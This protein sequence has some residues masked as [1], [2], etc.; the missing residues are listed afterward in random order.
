ME[1]GPVSS[2]ETAM[3]WDLLAVQPPNGERL[4]ARLAVP[5]RCEDVYI[6]VDAALRRYVLI[7]VPYGEPATLSE[8]VSRGIAVQTVEMTVDAGAETAI[9]VEV[10]CLESSGHAA[11]D[12]VTREIVEALAAGA[13]LGRIRL[14]QSVLAKWRRF[15]SGIAQNLLSKEEQLGLFGELWFL[16]RWLLPSVGAQ[17]AVPMW[18]G[19]L[20]AR[21]DFEAPGLA[22]EVK[23]SGRLDG[24]HRIHGL[25]QLLEPEGGVLLLFSLLVREEGGGIESLPRLVEEVRAV[26]TVDQA[27]LVQFEAVLLAAGYEDGHAPEYEKV[28][29]RMRGQGLYRVMG[30]FPRLIP[31]SLNTGLP[32]GV[33][34]VSYELRLDAADAW[35]LG[36]NPLA[37]VK[38]LDELSAGS[39]V[40]Q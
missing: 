24:S 19:P 17:R 6:A 18:R 12:I 40:S 7:K 37:A 38:L 20:G 3:R 30:G 10:A 14:V 9:F 35:L 26:L 25:E 13:S 5:S 15:W 8:R 4:A 34:N 22:V 29:L 11:L 1:I 36:A 39:S 23:T 33:S 16:S 31:A 32:V 21:N 28:G 2:H 27:Q